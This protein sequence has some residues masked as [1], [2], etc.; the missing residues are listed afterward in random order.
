MSRRQARRSA[1]ARPIPSLSGSPVPISR[2]PVA[3]GDAAELVLYGEVG[4][5]ITAA[6][7]R[8]QLALM[9]DAKTITVR[10]NSVGGE[11][12]DGIAIYTALRQHSARKV[13]VVE[14]IAASIASV[15]LCAC[16]EVIVS[17]GSFVMIHQC[18]GGVAGTAQDMQDSADYLRKIN[19]E[20]VDIYAAKTGKPTVEIMA[21]LDKG[22][23]YMTADEAVSFGIATSVAQA[24]ARYDLKAVAKLD[25]TKIPEPLKALL[26]EKSMA[27]DDKDKL[28]KLEEENAKLKAKLAKLEEGDDDEEKEADEPA[29]DEED[30]APEDSDED[31]DEDGEK[32]EEAKAALK[33][34]AKLTGKKSYAAMQGALLAKFVGASAPTEDRKSAVAELVRSGKLPPAMKAV[35]MGMSAKAFAAFAKAAPVIVPVG[36]R[37][38]APTTTPKPGERQVEGKAPGE[39]ELTDAEK[40]VM[41]A[42]NK[43]KAHM[44]SLRTVNPLT[45]KETA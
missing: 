45:S 28:A 9:P 11:V 4:E 15:I 26:K 7:V 14:G 38:S 21:L 23:H 6:S 36:Q 42:M 35:A 12:S 40:A 2:A 44:L 17:K 32:K 31:E 27:D 13:A 37:H 5:D 10:V 33:L 3:K 8:E 19:A 34:L 22:D 20:M 41:K 25:S 24:S 43:T 1:P 16:D 30:D 39:E 18:S 29:H